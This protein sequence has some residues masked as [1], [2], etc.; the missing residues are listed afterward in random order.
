MKMFSATRKI[1]PEVP[2]SFFHFE[3]FE[4]LCGDFI[5]IDARINFKA[6][7][8]I[9]RG[10]IVYFVIEEPNRFNSPDPDFRREK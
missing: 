4:K 6:L 2:M 9:E 1:S 3:R 8:K 10:K 7:E 5:F